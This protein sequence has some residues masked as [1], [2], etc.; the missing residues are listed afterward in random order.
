MTNIR[1]VLAKA[2]L[3]ATPTPA[4]EAITAQMAR[5]VLSRTKKAARRF[6]EVKGVILGGSYAKGTWLPRHVDLDVFV[7]IDPATADERFEEV[8]LAV[9]DIAMRGYPRGKKFAQHPYTEATFEGLRVNI[10]PCFDVK[11]GEWR[12]AADRSPFHVSLVE[13]LPADSKAQ[14]RVLKLFMNGVGVY[15]AEIERQGFSGYVAEV[16]VM[17]HGD[18]RSVLEWFSHYSLPEVGRAFTLTDPVDSR[19]D[20]GIAV[21]GERLGLMVLAS[22]E[23]L[24]R[25]L[26]AYFGRMSGKSHPSLRAD[27]VAVVFSHKRLS[28]DTLWGELRRTTRHIVRHLEVQGFTIARSLAASDND[29]RS[30]ILLLP[31]FYQL[32]AME[33]RLGPTVDRRK[34]VEA[35]MRSNSKESR[36]VWIDDEA[37]V[38]LLRPRKDTRLV[39]ALNSVARG[40]AGPVGASKELEAGMKRS[41]SVLTGSSLAREASSHGWLQDGIKEITSDAIGAR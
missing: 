32:P 29:S 35:F 27:V 6:P 11:K 33:Q 7:R 18:F 5:T 41:A 38:R 1:A 14:V 15:G 22:R 30:A 37:R 4:V 34:D 19:R 26:G 12:S 9:G 3:A 2:K 13:K 31:E 25:P 8:G 20:L 10:V 16:L 24:R 21:S 28:E 36:L 17:E 40:R 39:D 23:F